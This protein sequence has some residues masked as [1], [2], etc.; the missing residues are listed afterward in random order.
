MIKA[1]VEVCPVAG[2]EFDKRAFKVLS[3]PSLPSVGDTLWLDGG[4]HDSGCAEVVEVDFRECGG[5]MLV[6]IYAEDA[7][8]VGSFRRDT[9]AEMGWTFGQA[10]G[11]CEELLRD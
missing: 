5:F 10:I 2:S 9:M 7:P 1:V 6:F 3:F 11:R 4:R 8:E